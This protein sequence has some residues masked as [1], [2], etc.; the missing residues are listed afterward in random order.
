MQIPDRTC[1]PIQAKIKVRRS[2]SLS[3]PNLIIKTRTSQDSST[4]RSTRNFRLPLFAL[5]QRRKNNSNRKPSR[6][7]RTRGCSYFLAKKSLASTYTALFPRI[8]IF[9]GGEDGKDPRMDP[10]CSATVKSR[11]PF[12]QKNQRASISLTSW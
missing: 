1:K 11:P 2:H 5:R 12:I 10:P 3:V 4:F 8:F 9:V 7:T 6:L